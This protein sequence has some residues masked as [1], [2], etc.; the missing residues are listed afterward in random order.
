MRRLSGLLLVV[1]VVGIAPGLE[2]A[3]WGQARGRRGG[4]AAPPPAPAPAAEA[5]ANAPAPATVE[6]FRS[7]GD[8]PID[9]QHIRLDLKVDLLKKSIDARATLKLRSLRPLTNIS[10]DAVDFEVKNVSLV[11]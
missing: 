10:L 9:I 3:A 11:N 8:R 5:P 2:P 4:Q 6:P 7:A 1:L